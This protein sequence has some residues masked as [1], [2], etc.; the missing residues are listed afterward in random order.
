MRTLL[1]LTIAIFSFLNK[2]EADT[3][4]SLQMATHE[5][6]VNNIDRFNRYFPQ[7]KVYL[8]FDN[9]GYFLDEKIWF[10]AYVMRADHAVATNLSKILYVELVNPSGDV[11]HTGKLRIENGQAD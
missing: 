3:P 11:V 8:H 2:S 6:F 1:F 9:T 7:E 5:K 10:K 4:N